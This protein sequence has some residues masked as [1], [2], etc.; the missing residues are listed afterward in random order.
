MPDH[1]ARS[2]MGAHGKGKK[3]HADFVAHRLQYT[4]VAF[5]AP[6]KMNKIHLP[7]NRHKTHNKSKHV[8]STNED[9]HL[10]K[11]LYVTM[12]V[13]EGNR[14]CQFE[15]ENADCPPSLSKHGALRGGQK[16][17]LL[18]CLEIECPSDFDE[19]DAKLIDG[20]HTVHI[21]RPDASIKSFRDYANNNVIPYIERQLANITELMSSGPL[22][23]RQF[24]SND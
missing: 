10:L 9:K 4:A 18:S 20:A 6:I 23:A 11:Q 19:A 1:V 12:N 14:G 5:H 24:K 22:S 16:S 13:R 3:Q 21:F 15:V 17:D 7:G 2:I 8:D